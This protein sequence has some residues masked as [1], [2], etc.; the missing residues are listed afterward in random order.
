MK[1]GEKLNLGLRGCLE[2]H[3]RDA[4]TGQV[5][6][7][8]MQ[9]N[10]PASGGIAWMLLHMISGEGATSQVLNNVAVG[11]DTTAPTTADGALGSEFARNVIGTWDTSGLTATDGPNFQAQVNLKWLHYSAQQVRLGS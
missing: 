3:L 7:R 9:K 10:L 6:Q 2:L 5:V 4:R 8:V 1:V 11:T